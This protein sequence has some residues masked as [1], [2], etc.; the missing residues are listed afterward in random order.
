MRKRSLQLA[1]VLAVVGV[2]LVAA[3][4]V[5]AQHTGPAPGIPVECVDLARY[6]LD[7][8][9]RVDGNDFTLWVITVHE[10]G[11]QCFLG[12]PPE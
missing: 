12:G 4:A 8:N 5:Q 1:L 3:T 6:D 7:H 2:A 10:S 9:G 11:E